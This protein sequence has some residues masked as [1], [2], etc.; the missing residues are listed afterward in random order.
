MRRGVRS[1]HSGGWKFWGGEVLLCRTIAAPI[2][3]AD[4]LAGLQ[5]TVIVRWHR[6][7]KYLLA[8]L[9]A[10]DP[11]LV[12]EG[13]AGW[14][15][16]HLRMTGQLLWLEPDAPLHKHTR[17]RLFFAGDRELRFVDQRTFGQMWWV[18]PPQSPAAVISGL[19]HLGPE[20][21]SPDF[22][23]EYLVEQL[24]HRRRPIK[25]CPPGPVPG[26][27]GGKYLC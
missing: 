14:L 25:K 21:F 7:G 22:S 8:E 5:G 26:G 18:A 27:G 20:P 19:E 15:G 17:V 1:T 6:R 24:R 3:V 12:G 13:A 9:K 16:V 2:A 10:A 11:E 4:F 23:L